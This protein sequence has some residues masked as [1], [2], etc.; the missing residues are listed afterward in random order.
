M[1]HAF[2]VAV[3]ALLTGCA[4]AT[5]PAAAGEPGTAAPSGRRTAGVETSHGRRVADL[6]ACPQLNVPAGNVLAFHAYARGVQI[7]RWSGAGWTF[8]APSAVLFATAGGTGAVGTHF[9]G[10]TWL[11]VSGSR[12][13]GTVVAPCTPDPDAIPW[14]LLAA[15]PA[16]GPGVFRRATFIQRVNTVGGR[17]PAAPGSFTGQET[18]VPYTAEYLFYRAR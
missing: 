16:G 11:S 3:A 7:Y 8:V 15:T 12:V 5:A 4:D 10:P 13:V 14:L 17:A 2:V 9:A 6:D 1:G 18:T